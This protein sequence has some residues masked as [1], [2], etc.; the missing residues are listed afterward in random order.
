MFNMDVSI[1]PPM[2]QGRT[3]G[4][5][6]RQDGTGQGSTEEGRMTQGSMEQD[7]MTHAERH[8]A[9]QVRVT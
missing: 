6:A 9:R 3:E 2:V 5:R 7:R 4:S 8:R 1:I